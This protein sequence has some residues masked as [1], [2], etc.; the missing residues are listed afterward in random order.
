MVRDSVFSV[1]EAKNEMEKRGW[2]EDEEGEL[3]FQ[4]EGTDNGPDETWVWKRCCNSFPKTEILHLVSPIF[5]FFSLFFN[6]TGLLKRD[7]FI[8]GLTW[9]LWLRSYIQSTWHGAGYITEAEIMLCP[10]LLSSWGWTT[11]PFYFPF[12]CE[13]DKMLQ[14]W[15]AKNDV[16]SSCDRL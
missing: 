9:R 16:S 7:W 10:C 15:I 13:G 1:W 5:F 12:A 11:L 2:N 3:V 6:F 4:W 14:D 8:S